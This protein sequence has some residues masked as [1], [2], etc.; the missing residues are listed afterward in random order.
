MLVL[1]ILDFR[2]AFFALSPI[3][4]VLS[5][6]LLPATWVAL[7]LVLV[8][9]AVAVSIVCVSSAVGATVY[10]GRSVHRCGLRRVY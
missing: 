9:A 3:A 4:M 8:Q 5:W 7:A 10:S 1:S 6:T 2:H